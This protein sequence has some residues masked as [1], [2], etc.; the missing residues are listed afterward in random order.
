VCQ[1][2]VVGRGHA[3]SVLAGRDGGKCSNLDCILPESFEGEKVIRFAGVIATEDPQL[4]FFEEKSHVIE[5]MHANV[6][7]VLVRDWVALEACKSKARKEAQGEYLKP[8]LGVPVGGHCHLI[9]LTIFC[10]SAPVLDDKPFKNGRSAPKQS[11][12]YFAN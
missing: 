8:H 6:N 4:A 1:C 10:Q 2:I 7:C 5:N 9:G 11:L 3:I 12:Y